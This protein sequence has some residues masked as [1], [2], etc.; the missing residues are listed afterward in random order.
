MCVC[1]CMGVCVVCVSVSLC[2]CISCFFLFLCS[3][4]EM[5]THAALTQVHI[6]LLQLVLYVTQA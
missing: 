1:V 2:D 3:P 5:N 6:L 4:L